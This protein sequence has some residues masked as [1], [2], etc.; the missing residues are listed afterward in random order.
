MCRDEEVRQ[1]TSFFSASTPIF[2]ESLACLEGRVEW[3]RQLRERGKPMLQLLLSVEFYRKF[4]ENNCVITNRPG[5][6]PSF[7]LYARPPEPYWIFVRM[8]AMTLV[9]TRIVSRPASNAANLRCRLLPCRREA[10]SPKPAF[11]A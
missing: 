9:S 11:R 6:G 5:I 7:E 3:Q 8:S 2:L 4:G 10:T 1:R